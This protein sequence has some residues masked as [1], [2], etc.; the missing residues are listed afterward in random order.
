MILTT[1]SPSDRPE[2]TSLLLR[3]QGAD[4]YVNLSEENTVL[5]NGFTELQIVMLRQGWLYGALQKIVC[6]RF[7]FGQ[8]FTLSCHKNLFFCLRRQSVTL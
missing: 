6:S 8:S 4:A 1:L 2:I 7:R 3:G 5:D